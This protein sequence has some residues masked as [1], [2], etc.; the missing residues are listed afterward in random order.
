MTCAAI[1]KTLRTAAGSED[2]PKH[3]EVS[4]PY[5]KRLKRLFRNRV[6]TSC[7]LPEDQITCVP[8]T[9]RSGRSRNTSS[10]LQRVLC[11]YHLQ[12]THSRFNSLTILFY[13][14]L[15]IFRVYP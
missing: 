11:D 13:T 2:S 4:P 10:S 14:Y 9:Q 6:G 3:Q 7:C 15:Q 1:S 8:E 12:K 5:T